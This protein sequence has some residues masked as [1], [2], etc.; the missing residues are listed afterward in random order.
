ML[1]CWS[2]FRSYRP[3]QADLQSERECRSGSGLW[4]CSA[5]QPHAVLLLELREPSGSQTQGIKSITEAVRSP[6]IAL[7]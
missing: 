4:A 6:T 7:D 5:D 1:T 3:E 2:P